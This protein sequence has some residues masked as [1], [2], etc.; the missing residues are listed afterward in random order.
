MELSAAM[1]DLSHNLHPAVLK[2]AGLVAALQSGCFRFGKQQG[3]PTTCEAEE[4]GAISD[5]VALCLYRIAHEALSNVARHAHAGHVHVRL[6]EKSNNLELT[7]AD[8]GVGFDPP[9]AANHLG[10]VSAQERARLLN[11]SLTIESTKGHGTIVRALVP[12]SQVR[13]KQA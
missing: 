9:L 2:H 13:T 6:S 4:V 10:L 5:E 11:G 1:R 3:I 7:V 12:M 8:D